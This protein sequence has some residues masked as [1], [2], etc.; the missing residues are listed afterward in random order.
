MIA[1]W[2]AITPAFV[3]NRF[4]AMAANDSKPYQ[5]KQI[6]SNDFCIPETLIT[7]DPASAQDFW[8]RHGVVIYKSLSGIRSRV[9]RLRPEHVPRLAD[10]TSCPTQFQQYVAGTE[11]RVHVVGDEISAAEV[12]CDADDYRYPGPHPVE[13]RACRLAESVED[14]CRRLAAAA[15]LPVAGLDLRRTADDRWYCFEVNSSPGFT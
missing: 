14:R 3:V 1:A 5:L 13:I 9:A 4:E 8:E 2:L 15:Q 12:Q 7:T 10:V 11:Y 6:L